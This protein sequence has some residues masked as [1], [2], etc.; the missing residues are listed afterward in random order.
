MVRFGQGYQS[1]GPACEEL[2]R[3]GPCPPVKPQG[4]PALR[5]CL[6]NV[7]LEQ[8]A[9][10]NIKITKAR[11][12]ERVDGATALAMAIGTAS[13]SPGASVYEMRP[14]FLTI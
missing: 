11:S 3:L 13:A 4:C 12:K 2:E 14:S 10:G 7:A 8:D 5:W 6:S 9:A 1:M